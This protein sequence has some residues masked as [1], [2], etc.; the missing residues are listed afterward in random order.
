MK[1]NTIIHTMVIVVFFFKYLHPQD[2][3]MLRNPMFKYKGTTAYSNAHSRSAFMLNKYRT[4]VTIHIINHTVRAYTI[5][6]LV[7]FFIIYSFANDFF[8]FNIL[9]NM[10][11]TQVTEILDA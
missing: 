4:F 10:I 2:N 9:F 11:I 3:V 5:I 1:N 7:L 8:P 6:V